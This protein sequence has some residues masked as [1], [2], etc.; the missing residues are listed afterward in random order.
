MVGSTFPTDSPLF[1]EVVHGIDGGRLADTS[2]RIETSQDAVLECGLK[3]IVFVA[4]T[5]QG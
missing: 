4:M 2:A 1:Y 3:F 5:T